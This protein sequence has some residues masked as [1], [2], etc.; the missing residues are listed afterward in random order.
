MIRTFIERKAY[1]WLYRNDISR[2]DVIRT[3]LRD[4][5]SP[6]KV[7]EHFARSHVLRGILYLLAANHIKKTGIRPGKD[8]HV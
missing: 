4:G 8:D 1:D 3:G 2:V 5:L 7:A 6:Q